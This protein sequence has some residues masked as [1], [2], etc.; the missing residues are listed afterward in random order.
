MRPEKQKFQKMLQLATVMRT[1]ALLDRT[2]HVCWVQ[3]PG[4]SHNKFKK[5][6]PPQLRTQDGQNVPC[7]KIYIQ[8]RVRTDCSNRERAR[9]PA[10]SAA[11][12]MSAFTLTSPAFS[13]SP[14][15]PKSPLE[16]SLPSFRANTATPACMCIK[17]CST[18]SVQR[19]TS[20]QGSY[21][22]ASRTHCVCSMH[23]AKMH[24]NI[25]EG[26]CHVGSKALGL[27]L[28]GSR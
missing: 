2:F 3:V 26:A 24:T 14:T 11:T 5:I 18:H 23:A 17:H 7:G 9:D 19:L 28:F 10:P 25:H 12:I 22:P 6:A 15:S 4:I 13:P 8:P 16:A 1:L 21:Q 27:R 20:E